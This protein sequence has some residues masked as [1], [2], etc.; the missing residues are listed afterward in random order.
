MRQ[1]A[2]GAVEEGEASLRPIEGRG[3]LPPRELAGSGGGHRRG[4]GWSERAGARG[5]R[6]RG[7]LSRPALAGPDAASARYR[8]AM[9]QSRVQHA[10]ALVGLACAAPLSLL[11]ILACDIA[12]TCGRGGS[13]ASSSAR[14]DM[15]L[16]THDG[17]SLGPARGMP[18]EL[19][20]TTFYQNLPGWSD[21]HTRINSLGL[22][23]LQPEASHFARVRGDFASGDGDFA[24]FPSLYDR[25]R[26]DAVRALEGRGI[27]VA[28]AVKHF[29]REGADASWF[30]DPVHPTLRG[31]GSVARLIDRRA[32]APEG[33][34]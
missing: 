33:T 7:E 9:A 34:G 10:P 3:R 27:P 4:R 31:A 18:L 22:R 19:S 30:L 12:L 15:N 1:A 28:D 23:V 13:G 11:L 32:P 21:A 2:N 16:V 20:P 14:F 29:E 8:A 17:A 24:H 6:R 26:R 5:L 25:F